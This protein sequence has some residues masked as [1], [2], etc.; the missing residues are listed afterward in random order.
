MYLSVLGASNDSGCVTKSLRVLIRFNG[1]FAI[2]V[3][4]QTVTKIYKLIVHSHN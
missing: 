2:S 4:K 3:N 1:N